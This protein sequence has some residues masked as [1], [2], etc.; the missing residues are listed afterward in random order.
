MFGTLAICLPLQHE[1]GDLIVRH[2]D[3]VKV[4]STAQESA[5]GYQYLF[6][7]VVSANIRDYILS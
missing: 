7:F 5:F 2:G 6:W 1:G 3:Q 4:L